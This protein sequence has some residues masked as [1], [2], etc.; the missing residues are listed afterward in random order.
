MMTLSQTAIPAQLQALICTDIVVFT[1]RDGALRLLLRRRGQTPLRWDLPGGYVEVDEDLD[2][3]AQRALAA[4]TGLHGVYLE[5]LYTFG[6]PGRQQRGRVVTVAYYALVAPDR[7]ADA[8]RDSTAWFAL[9]ELPSL[10]RDQIEITDLARQRLVA[11]LDYSTIAFEFMP[12]NFTL[13]ELQQVYEIILG[14]ELDKRNFRKRI[15]GLGC[16]EATG[17]QRREGS[18]RPARLY[19][20]RSP[21]ELQYIK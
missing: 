3:C 14:A 16:I 10:N 2:G 11:K 20:Y 9:T 1:I 15:L 17:E 6:H 13:S 19:R 7:L 21:G 12:E 18:H 8:T 4:Q 5:Q